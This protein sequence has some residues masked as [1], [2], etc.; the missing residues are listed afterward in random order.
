MKLSRSYCFRLLASV[1]L[2][3]VVAGCSM[4]PYRYQP[5][6]SFGI[7]QRAQTQE[8]GGFKVMASVPGDEEAEALFGIPLSKRGIQAVWLKITNNSDKRGRFAPY[9]IDDSYFPPHE[10]AYMYRKQFSK[11]GWLDMEK[12]F[13]EM[14]IPRYLGPG[15]TVSG[16]VFTNAQMGT[17]SFNVDLFY[18]GNKSG[19]EHFTFF[20]NVPGFKPDHANVN[21]KDL[22]AADELQDIDLEAFRTLVENLPCC[23]TN[24]DGTKQGQPIDTILV[25]SGIDL[26]QAL[27]RAEWSET[28]Y[29]RSDDYLNASDYF[30][31]RPPDA[32]F[33]KGRDK[34]TERNEMGLWLTPIRVDGVPVWVAQ[35]KHAIGRRYK[36]EEQFLGVQLDPD[37]NDG[38]NFLMQ[39]LWYSEALSQ[40]AW[41]AS[42]WKVGKSA[43]ELDFNNN[44]WFSDGYR[45]VLWVSGE[46]VSHS[47]VSNVDWDPVVVSNGE[48][49]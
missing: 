26:L 24:N 27:L 29:V 33:R 14:S 19:Y 6:E 37:V 30:Y 32:I 21:F 11:Q 49:Q 5:L 31:G 28:S 8:L 44:A 15:E 2:A 45:L 10:V 41:S 46:P 47:E 39:N 43:P 40:V 34:T 25:S 38:R 16:F 18:A 12:R 3:M 17:K 4:T 20:I 9:S 7:E 13:F 42:G 23:T 36:I 22:Y 48:L 1:F 35:I